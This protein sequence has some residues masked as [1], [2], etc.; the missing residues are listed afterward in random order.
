MNRRKI[1]YLG[2]PIQKKLLFFIC[3]AALIPAGIVAVCLYYLIFNLLAGQLAIPEAIAYTLLP[4]A[5]RVNL[6]ILVSLPTVLV[7]IWLMALEFSNRVAGPLYRIEKELDQ[8]ISGEKKG[9]IRLRSKDEMKDLVD[10]I[11]KILGEE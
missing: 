9:A 8:R 7:V 11:N 4:V 6:I 1:K 10:K 5:R 3:I 2:T